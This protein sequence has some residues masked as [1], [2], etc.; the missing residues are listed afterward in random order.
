MFTFMTKTQQA[1]AARILGGEPPTKVV[2]MSELRSG[3]IA[4]EADAKRDAAQRELLRLGMVRALAAMGAT[5]R[6]MFLH[7]A[8]A[9]CK[10][11]AAMGVD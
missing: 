2:D 1:T 5:T 4:R 8:R 11:F 7:H 3:Q 6:A 10:H 9:A